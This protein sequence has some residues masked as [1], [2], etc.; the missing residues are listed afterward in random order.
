MK[1]AAAA[2]VRA[3]DAGRSWNTAVFHGPREV[4]V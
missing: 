3:G 4:P 2:A 1:A